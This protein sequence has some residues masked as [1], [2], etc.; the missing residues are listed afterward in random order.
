MNAQS[1]GE[2]E[3]GG[4]LSGRRD[5]AVKGCVDKPQDFAR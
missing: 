1:E 3:Q 2:Q 5:K 4:R